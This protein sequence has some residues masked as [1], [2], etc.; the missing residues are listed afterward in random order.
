MPAPYNERMRKRLFM[1]A[2]LLLLSAELVAEL[3]GNRPEQ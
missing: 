3:N 2:S 1:A